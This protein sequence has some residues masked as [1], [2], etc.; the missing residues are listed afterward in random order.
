[1]LL[2]GRANLGEEAVDGVAQHAGLVVEL[3]GVRQHVGC[4]GAGG[5]GRRRDAA[6]MGVDLARACRDL[7]DVV[8]DLARR[9]ALLLDRGRDRDRDLAHLRN[10]LRN[11]VDRRDG[12][13][14]RLLHGRDLARDLLGR[15]RGLVGERLDFGGE[16][17]KAAAAFAGTRRLDGR[18]QRQ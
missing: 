12:V 15:L 14:G 2:L 9:I 8:R 17:R 10:R 6:D 1:M 18:V 4:R 13:A 3:A 7:L 5:G 16:H 11:S